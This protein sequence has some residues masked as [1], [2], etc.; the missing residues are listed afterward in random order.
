MSKNINLVDNV[1]ILFQC[2]FKLF[3]QYQSNSTPP[4]FTP[5]LTNQRQKFNLIVL[6]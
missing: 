3:D 2:F 5:Y 6:K 1:T 4:I